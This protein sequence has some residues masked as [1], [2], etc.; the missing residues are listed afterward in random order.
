MD[1]AIEA[2][3]GRQLRNA[4]GERVRFDEPLSRHTSFRIGGPAD[5]WVEAHTV[6]EICRL[7]ELA[8]EKDLPLVVFG[9]GT[10]VLVADRGVRGIVLVLGP[11]FAAL[12]WTSTES[13]AVVRAGAA[14]RLKKLVRETA[15]RGLSGL[16]FAEGIPG[17]IGGGLL[18]NAGA[19]GGELAHAIEAVAGVA[20]AV[21]PMRLPRSDLRFGYRFFDLPP[22]FVVTH[23]EFALRHDEPQ[24]VRE[25]I[26]EAKRRRA[27]HQPL[28]LP[29]AG[30]IFRNPPGQFAG[31]LIEAAGLKGKQVGGARV[32]ERHANFIVNVGN[33]K[34]ADVKRLI[35]D[36]TQAVW[37]ANAVRLVP[38]VKLLG[39]WEAA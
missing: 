12:D 36:I 11:P 23:V 20:P 3:V 5:A 34:A 30:S 14:T 19:F 38:E 24:R 7:L 33:A 15:D 10:N 32:S 28:G 9:G 8:R 26:S 17:S 6:A 39:D 2:D 13:G 21:G 25:R 37:E 4:F 1:G 31:K 22:G 18:M 16:E 27:R 35:D 29:N